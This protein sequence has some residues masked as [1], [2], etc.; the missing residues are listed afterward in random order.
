[1]SLGWRKQYWQ[2]A[3][4]IQTRSLPV[5]AMTVRGMDGVPTAMSIW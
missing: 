3:H 5:S 2:G 1:M 4:C